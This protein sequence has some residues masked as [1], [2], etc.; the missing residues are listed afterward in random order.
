MNLSA[1]REATRNSGG[2]ASDLSRVVRI[3]VQEVRRLLI[4]QQVG[5]M[6]RGIHPTIDI[7]DVLPS[8][9][10]AHSELPILR[11]EVEHR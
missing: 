11:H 2:N 9:F 7:E 6:G 4:A 3:V 8:A 5:E 1:K 10:L